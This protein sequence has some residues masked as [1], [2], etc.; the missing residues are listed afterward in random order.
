ME[1]VRWFIRDSRPWSDYLELVQ[2]RKIEGSRFVVSGIFELKEV[3]LGAAADWCTLRITEPEAQEI[4]DR[5][6]QIGIRPRQGEGAIAHVGALR[7]HLKDLQHIIFNKE[8][9]PR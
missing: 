3:P 7:E 6:W 8:G 9:D 2:T 4:M 1:E 5:L